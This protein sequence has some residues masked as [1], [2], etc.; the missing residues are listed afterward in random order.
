MNIQIPMIPLVLG[1]E[2]HA[3]APSAH[4]HAYATIALHWAAAAAILLAAGSVLWREWVENDALRTLLMQVHKQAGLFVLLAL[5]ARIAVRFHMGF[6]DHAGSMHL[7]MRWAA[8]LAH[9]GLYALLLSL[10][11]LGLAVCN[12]S[13]IDVSF[14]GLFRLPSLVRDDPDLAATLPDAHVWAAWVMLVMVGLHVVAALWHHV[15][16]R[17]I[18]LVAMLPW[19]RRR[20]AV[21][22]RS[23]GLNPV[24][25]SKGNLGF[26]ALRDAA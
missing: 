2:Q 12:A 14:F 4:R 7:L 26:K 10:P 23:A 5:V 9:L 21:A 3:A 8:H 13:A 1:R 11:V 17:D 25:A 18:V 15:V 19:V 16:R 6:Q 20:R 22:V 24:P